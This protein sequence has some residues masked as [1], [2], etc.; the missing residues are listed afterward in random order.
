MYATLNTVEL[1]LEKMNFTKESDETICAYVAR[2]TDTADMCGMN[3]KCTS[4]DNSYRDLVVHQLLVIHGM[5]QPAG[6]PL[7]P[8]QCEQLQWEGSAECW[9]G[10]QLFLLG[11]G[12]LILSSPYPPPD[13]PAKMIININA[14]IYK[15]HVKCMQK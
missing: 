2:V 3:M 7:S 5:R 14:L 15:L 11:L 1:F 13:I 12:I 10:S 9:A 4:L 6:C 8:R